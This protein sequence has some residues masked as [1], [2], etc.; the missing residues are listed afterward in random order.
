M[1]AAAV[2][3]DAWLAECHSARVVSGRCSSRYSMMSSSTGMTHSTQPAIAG[4]ARPAGLRAS[5]PFG[6]EIMGA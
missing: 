1:S 6:S 3:A 5:R 4:T 2:W